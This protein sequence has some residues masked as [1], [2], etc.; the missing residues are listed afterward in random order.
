M[1]ADLTIP[2]STLYDILTR[3]L[4]LKRYTSRWVPH[5]LT[6]QQR[7]IRVEIAQEMAR[8]LVS[9]SSHPGDIIT[10]DESWFFHE[11]PHSG[12]WASS[13]EEAGT[14]PK[15]PTN[16][17]TMVVI[18]W[19][20]RGPILIRHLEHGKR[21][22]SA[23]ACGLLIELADIIKARRPRTG[24]RGLILHWDNARPHISRE[25]TETLNG[26]G[27]K[28]L[29]HPPYSPDLAPSDFFLFGTLKWML[30]GKSF[31]NQEALLA[32][33]GA[34]MEEISSDTFSKVYTEWIERATKVGEGDGEYIIH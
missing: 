16:K 17:K 19:S 3:D 33:L 27:F 12:M 4:E 29:A 22:D 24:T 6:P 18:F 10:C 2:K 14:R 31:S 34:C 7:R 26:L 20:V 32:Q 25:T 1:S 23:F 8:T 9:Y 13:R 21:F 11:Y 30:S 28:T 15:Q 5:S